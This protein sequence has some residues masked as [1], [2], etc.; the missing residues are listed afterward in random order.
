M[1]KGIDVSHWNYNNVITN[2]LDF[3]ICKA[4]EGEHY[5]DKTFNSKL[6]LCSQLGINLVGAYHYAKTNQDVLSNADNFINTIM[7]RKEFGDSMI[8]ALDIEGE[9]ANRKNAW[10][11][12]RDWCDL[13]FI[14]TGIKPVVYTSAYY[15]RYMKDLLEGN[16]GLWVAH[17]NVEKPKFNIYPFWAL[18]QYST[19]DKLDRDYFNG[20]KEQYLKYCRKEN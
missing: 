1:L 11:W 17:W 10:S 8:L 16:Y 4:T 19:K 18:W 20:T 13:V 6:D 2:D 7:T 5:K 15:T 3:C 14:N 12:C 9:D